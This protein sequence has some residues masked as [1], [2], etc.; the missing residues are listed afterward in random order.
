M[1]PVDVVHGGA[2]F[3]YLRWLQKAVL[4]NTRNIVYTC[5][6]LPG[7]NSIMTT[8]IIV[9]INSAETHNNRHA[10]LSSKYWTQD[11]TYKTYSPYK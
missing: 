7:V 8:I 6:K 10:P 1:W 9:Y 5:L 2:N 4:L 3:V 11:E